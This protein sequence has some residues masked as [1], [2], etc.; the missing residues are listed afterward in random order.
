[1]TQWLYLAGLL[2]SIGG[3]ALLDRRFKL[4]YWYDRRRTIITI[5][6]GVAVFTIWDLLAIKFGIF[7]H[8]DS[9][10]MLPFTILPEFPLEELF[11]LVLLC[12]CTLTAYR[13]GVTKWPRT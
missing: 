2:L 10:F 13:A 5:L 7:L 9:R 12:Y 11:F 8:G 4:A 1:M 3:V 6:V